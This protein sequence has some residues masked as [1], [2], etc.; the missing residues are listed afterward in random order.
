M[1]RKWGRGVFVPLGSCLA[2]GKW[3]EL[4]ATTPTA[5]TTFWNQVHA[6]VGNGD[7]HKLDDI[8]FHDVHAHVKRYVDSSSL[9]ELMAC[10][11]TVMS[12]ATFDDAILISVVAEH[13][14][15]SADCFGELLSNAEVQTRCAQR[16][17]KIAIH[18]LAVNGQF[19]AAETMW[20]RAKSHKRSDGHSFIGWPSPTQTPTVWVPGLS[21]R[22]IW[23]CSGWPFLQRLEEATPLILREMSALESEFATAYPYLKT[24]GI[25]EDIFL[26]RG[27]EWNTTLCSAMPQTCQLLLP[28]LPTRP[29]V[30]YATVYNE[31]IVIFRSRRGATVGA[32]CGSSNAVINLHL[33]LAGG[34]GTFLSV[35]G[36][37]KDLHDG[38]AM[39]F[40]DSYFHAVNHGSD[41][42]DE[43]ISLVIRVMHPELDW[44]ALS[45]FSGTDDVPDIQAWD[46]S[47]SL[48]KEVERLR[49][50]Y[51]KLAASG[52]AAVR[53][54]ACEP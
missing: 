45:A 5:C 47:G 19:E 53:A 17:Y 39:C 10:A 21:S 50:E 8:R 30:P 37:R 34:R 31:E 13:I 49:S 48:L 24:Q 3:T 38:K 11:E 33:T 52:T 46:R 22:A 42:A 27:H 40:Q 6:L 44:E 16:W 15:N 54:E 41:G 1:P 20:H 29:G 32:H 9:G 43:R 2:I 25:W 28:E 12:L 18:V 35:D 4:H 7:V 26:Y 36:E 51:R 14:A 23:D